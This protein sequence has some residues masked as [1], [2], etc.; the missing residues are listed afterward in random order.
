MLRITESALFTCTCYEAW[1]KLIEASNQVLSP[2]P[3]KGGEAEDSTY[4]CVPHHHYQSA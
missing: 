3:R 1:S 4:V 2:H